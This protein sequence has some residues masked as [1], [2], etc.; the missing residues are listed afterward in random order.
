MKDGVPQCRKHARMNRVHFIGTIHG[1]RRVAS[2]LEGA[3][4]WPATGP[5]N[6]GDRKVKGSIPSPSANKFLG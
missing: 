5:E 3:A 6:Q 1:R 2:D 4:E